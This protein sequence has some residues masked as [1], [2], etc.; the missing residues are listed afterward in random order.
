MR[1]P[2][3]IRIAFAFSTFLPTVL[4][5]ILFDK[6]TDSDFSKLLT[7]QHE[8]QAAV[9]VIV[10]AARKYSLDGVV[11]EIWSQL[12]ARVDDHVLVGLVRAIAKALRAHGKQ[13]ILVVPPLRD[14]MHDLFSPAHFEQLVDH[15][16]GFSL[17]TYDY[18]SA[19]RPGPNAPKYWVERAVKH[20]CPD[21]VKSLKEK[22]SKILIGLNMYGND[23][24][25]EGG[26]SILGRQ[27]LEFVKRL[28]GR[29]TLDEKDE[30]NFFDVK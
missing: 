24:T 6:F 3:E 15:V 2:T 25:T 17:M 30:E 7:H 4:P 10:Q 8:Q 13:L 11:L 1:I 14:H 21:G 26:G 9:A 20:I 18:S 28:P 27:Y 19:E 22:R 23:Y 16:A 12:S 5:R 29:L